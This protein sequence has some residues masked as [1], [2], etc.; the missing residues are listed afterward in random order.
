MHHTHDGDDLI[1]NLGKIMLDQCR[2]SAFLVAD[3]PQLIDNLVDLFVV[4]TII[5][6]PAICPAVDC[7]N[8]FYVSSCSSTYYAMYS[9]VV[10]LGGL[11]CMNSWTSPTEIYPLAS[12][13]SSTSTASSVDK[14]VG[15]IINRIT[16]G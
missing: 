12:E 13:I 15:T 6:I 16:N 3:L 9:G 10:H 14:R 1:L 5:G 11:R 4:V 8:I 7:F 2:I